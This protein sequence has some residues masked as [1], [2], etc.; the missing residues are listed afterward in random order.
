M[1]AG[2]VDGNA[3]TAKELTTM[4]RNAGYSRTEQ[5]DLQSAPQTVLVTWR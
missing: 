5:F 4:F 3:Y 2:T 1:L